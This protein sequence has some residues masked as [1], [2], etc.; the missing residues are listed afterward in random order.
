MA[1]TEIL[2]GI[3]YVG[4]ND[5]TTTRFEA[6][7]SLPMGVSYNAYLVAGE[8]IAL[9][10]TVEESFG[11]R[12]E[13]NIREAIGDRKIDYL[14]INHME[15]D[16]EGSLCEV[17]SACK[18]E[19]IFCSTMAL[20][21][22]AGYYG[23]KMKD[24]P[25]QAVKSGDKISIGKH[26]LV[27]QETRML[28]WPDSMVTYCPEAKILFS[29]DAFGQNIAGTERF[30]DEHE[31]GDFI[32]RA[33][34]YYF[35][36]VLPYSPQVLKTL[37]VVR[38]LDIDMIAPDH[39]LISRN[40]SVKEIIDLYETMAEQKPRKRAV[41][42][43]DTM[44]H[45]TEQMAYAVCSGFEDNGVPAT[46]MSCKA[47]HHSAIMTALSD[48]SCLVVGSPTHNNTILPYVMS[49]LTY[50]KGLRPKILVG[51]AFGSYG[52][53][54]E[55]PKVLQQFLA[56][57][58]IELPCEPVRVNWRPGHEGLK[59]AYDLGASLAKDLK[60]KCGE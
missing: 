58:K 40:E 30:V 6:L 10:D 46:V 53:S 51:G 23:D 47:N 49:A 52:W 28:H 8:K 26:T 14:V 2:P 33:K 45:S 36:I 16:H 37:P 35:N 31:H 43:Y 15:L 21:S 27:F 13:A 56:D 18:P 32:R 42:I 1:I 17:I 5:R 41:I 19:K 39:G 59:K 7:W 48:A 57:M 60:A 11:S 55:S 20:K 50:I 3:H 25:V 24:W 9:I 34:E 4:V 38:S 54:G 22:M 44:W 12:L 29:Q